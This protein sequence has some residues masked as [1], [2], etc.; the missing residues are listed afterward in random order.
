MDMSHRASWDEA[1]RRYAA[2]VFHN[3][4][5]DAR[6]PVLPRFVLQPFSRGVDLHSWTRR[7]AVPGGGVPGHGSAGQ[8]RT[9][10][11]PNGCTQ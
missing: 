2:R 1:W 9:I 5:K 10:A 4:S 7:R 8:E 11:Y 6:V 3:W